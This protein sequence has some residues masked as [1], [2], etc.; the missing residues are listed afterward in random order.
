ML[1]I[2][3]EAKHIQL[4]DRCPTFYSICHM[5]SWCMTSTPWHESCSCCKHIL[6]HA[7]RIIFWASNRA[8]SVQLSISLRLKLRKGGSPARLTC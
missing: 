1:L 6:L 5:S 2:A 3:I 8:R 4:Q 7:L